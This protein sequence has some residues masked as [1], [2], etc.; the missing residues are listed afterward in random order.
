VPAGTASNAWAISHGSRGSVKRD[1]PGNELCT[2]VELGRIGELCRI[3]EL[4]RIV[5]QR[6]LSSSFVCIAELV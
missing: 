6:V 2:R 3:G 1:A 4:G 5:V